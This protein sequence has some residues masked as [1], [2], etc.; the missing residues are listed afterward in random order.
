[1]NTERLELGVAHLDCD[2]RAKVT[3]QGLKG[4]PGE[5]DIQVIHKSAKVLRSAPAAWA[6]NCAPTPKRPSEPA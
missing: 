3:V 2:S 6:T 5:P 4:T 1:M